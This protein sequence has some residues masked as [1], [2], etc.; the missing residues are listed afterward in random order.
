MNSWLGLFFKTVKTTYPDEG[1]QVEVVGKSFV[2]VVNYS[3]GD[4][5]LRTSN[6]ITEQLYE[7]SSKLQAAGG[8]QGNQRG[9]VVMVHVCKRVFWNCYFLISPLESN[10]CYLIF[11]VARKPWDH[12]VQPFLDYK[13]IG[14]D[15]SFRRHLF[16]LP[17]EN[18]GKFCA[19]VHWFQEQG[20][21]CSR[22]KDY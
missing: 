15:I 18:Q 5:W 22:D 11:L 9:L 3:P 7:I 17:T 4:F 16:Q 1:V 13:R 2:F 6:S 14:L 12:F 21:R 10:W 20:R 19:F 8:N